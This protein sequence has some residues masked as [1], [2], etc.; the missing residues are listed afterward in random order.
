MDGNEPYITVLRKLFRDP[1]WTSE[2]FTKS[3]AWIDLLYWAFHSD[4]NFKWNGR[5][6]NLLRG[7]FSHT[8][9]YLAK[10]W[11]WTRSKVH[12]LLKRWEVLGM[13]KIDK[14]EQQTEQQTE[15]RTEQRTEQPSEQPKNVI[16]ICNYHRYQF[17]PTQYEQPNEQRTEQRS[18][19]RT[20]Q[21]TEH[22]KNKLKEKIN[23][24]KLKEKININYETIKSNLKTLKTHQKII[25]W[26]IKNNP[27]EKEK[28]EKRLLHILQE[29]KEIQS[30][31]K[32]SARHA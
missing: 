14:L 13:I 25:E 32:N 8:E 3:Q 23:K 21:R 28:A 4:G 27:E 6:Y 19:Q 26:E 9:N 31:L 11:Q 5:R 30:K 24:N 16:T 2:P 20:E 18:E 7:Q 12:R 29:Q 10:R 17:I 1:M 22:N 15:Q